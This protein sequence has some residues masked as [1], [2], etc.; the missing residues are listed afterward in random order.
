MVVRL[1]ERDLAE[2]LLHLATPLLERLGPTPPVDDARTAIELAIKLW[3]AHVTASKVW[4]VPRPKPLAYLRKTT[5]G[6]QGPRGNAD[7]FSLLSERWR[8]EFAFDPRLVGKWSYEPTEGG[9]CQLVCET[10]FPEGVEPEVPPAV[11]RR[12]AIGGS[13]L[14][15][16]RIRLDATSYLLF[17]V[18]QH[19][20]V[21]NADGV[22]TVH[23]KMPTVVQLF[24]EGRLPPIGGP[25]VG[26][27][28]GGRQL[29]PMVLTEVRCAGAFGH[30]DVA[31]LVFR[32]A[33]AGAL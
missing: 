30:N 20:G 3:N 8:E 7:I 25:P 24:A 10:T 31:V 5:R 27:M 9:R 26:V 22:A 17:P 18:E 33:N 4:G 14:D 19:R 6:E 12:I 13:F 15:E 21:V 2:S 32:P 16:M 29:G 1:P 23:A 11:E 28:V